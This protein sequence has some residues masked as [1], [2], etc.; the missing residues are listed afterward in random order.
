MMNG[1]ERVT[2][3]VRKVPK[4]TN[5]TIIIPTTERNEGKL[6]RATKNVRQGEGGELEVG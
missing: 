5:T 2:I 6:T 1:R 3:P 4:N